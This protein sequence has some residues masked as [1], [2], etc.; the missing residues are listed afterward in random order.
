MRGD[1]PAD[2]GFSLTELLVSMMIFSLVLVS[3]LGVLGSFTRS[4][5]R[6]EA[7]GANQA[8]VRLA[9]LQV[10]RDVQAAEHVGLLG[11]P[12][13]Y[14][15]TLS[16][17]QGD[18]CVQWDTTGGQLV[19]AVEDPCGDPPSSRVVLGDVAAV[20]TDPVFSYLRPGGQT[21]A[22]TETAWDFATCADRVVVH[23]AGADDPAAPRFT[24][25]G[26]ARLRAARR[27]GC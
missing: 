27:S 6:H 10:Q 3:V 9:L 17:D 7:Q 15:G 11:S 21:I 22:T 2:A 25:R 13:A 20:G 14:A 24:V 5:R 18:R 23:L 19:R 12:G 1:A 8:A 16:L 4:E 26:D